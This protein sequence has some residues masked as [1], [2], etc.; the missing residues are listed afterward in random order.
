MSPEEIRGIL[1]ANSITGYRIGK[2]TPINQVT[3]DNFLKGKSTPYKST[4][5]IY[6]TYINSGFN[7]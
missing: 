4:L 5:E 1:I 3:A 7:H 6:K 2:D